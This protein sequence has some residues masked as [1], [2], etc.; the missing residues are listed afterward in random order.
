[1]Q[2]K[3]ASILLCMPFLFLCGCAVSASSQ[4][5]ATTSKDLET[6]YTLSGESFQMISSFDPTSYGSGNQKG[7]YSVFLN[8]DG[9]SNIMYTDYATQT[10]VYLC[11]KPTVNMT[12]MPE[13]HGS[14][15]L[16][17]QLFR[18]QQKR[19]CFSFTAVGKSGQ[20]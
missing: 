7:F 3:T 14:R 10:Q 9:S 2:K 5:Q 6:E 15:L 1:M 13:P 4:V 11:A 8:D 19:I 18:R 20:K 16:P 17:A 12:Q